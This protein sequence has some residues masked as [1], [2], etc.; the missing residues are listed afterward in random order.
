M[1]TLSLRSWPV[2]LALLAGTA[3]AQ[4]DQLS[5]T[6]RITDGDRKLDGCEVITYLAN[7]PQGKTIT[8]KSGKFEVHLK[9]NGEYALELRKEGFVSKRIVVDTRSTVDPAELILAPLSM[10]VS[11]L[12]VE[13]Y[14]GANTDELDFPFAIVRYSKDQHAFVQDMDY[15]MG[16]QRTNGALL[17]MAARAEKRGK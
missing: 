5:V 16:M 14:Q 7:E 6:G 1:R 2:F 9:L 8:D 4:D 13:R 11:L 15:T 10:D 3:Q 12:P 17:L